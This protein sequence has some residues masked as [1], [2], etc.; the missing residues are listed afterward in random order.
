LATISHWGA[1]VEA[2]PE[3]L[4]DEPAFGL[5]QKPM[6]DA[7]AEVEKYDVQVQGAVLVRGPDSVLELTVYSKDSS[8]QH[9]A[10]IPYCLEC[11]MPWPAGN[12]HPDNDCPMKVVDHVM[13]T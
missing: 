3:W 8:R 10:K 7:F 6:A 13:S 11:Q 9:V 12:P 4:L 1:E 2:D 5:L